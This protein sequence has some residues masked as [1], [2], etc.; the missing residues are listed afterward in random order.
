[1]MRAL[2]LLL[3]LLALAGPL[4][5]QAAE[6]ARQV[7]QGD[8]LT[9]RP[10]TAYLLLRTDAKAMGSFYDF[11]FLREEGDGPAPAASPP[12]LPAAAPAVPNLVRVDSRRLYAKSADSRFFLLSVPPGSY[13]VALVTYKRM[14]SA[15][16][17]LCM[18][19]VRFEAKPGVLTDLG[20]FLAELED[21]AAKIP[22]LARDT[23]PATKYAVAPALAA[24]TLR[25]RSAAMAVPD[26]LK[27]LRPV[28][29]DY[30]AVGK[31]PNYFHTMINRMAPVEGVLAYERDRAIDV[32]SAR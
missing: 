8:A 15:G 24:M 30:R 3:W 25:P 11:V 12:R 10:D 20:T 31:F 22:E 27:A 21:R 28:A 23:N 18:G 26:A 2:V 14:D 1:M 5:V 19:T 17:C 13:V 4:P 29:A 6:P 7:A 9:V 32:K 16:T